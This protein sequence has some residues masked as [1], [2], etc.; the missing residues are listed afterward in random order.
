[1]IK[2]SNK[3]GTKWLLWIKKLC[4]HETFFVMIYLM[5]RRETKRLFWIQK[6]CIHKILIVIALWPKI[7]CPIWTKKNNWGPKEVSKIFKF[8]KARAFGSTQ[9]M[10]MCCANAKTRTLMF[11]WKGVQHWT[12][13]DKANIHHL[14]CHIPTTPMSPSFST[15][16]WH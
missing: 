10:Q 4:I 7:T 1:M 3:G 14:L 12:M 8:G 6:L 16:K 13:Q 2:K 15:T 11:Y 9:R 5:K